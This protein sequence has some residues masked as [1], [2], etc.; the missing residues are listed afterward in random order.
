MSINSKNRHVCGTS[1]C[2]STPHFG[3]ILLRVPFNEN[4]IQNCAEK[5]EA[6]AS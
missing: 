1:G 2:Y 6:A 4:Q 5:T 3:F